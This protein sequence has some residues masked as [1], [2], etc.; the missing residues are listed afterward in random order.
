LPE[1]SKGL[2]RETKTNTLKVTYR[3]YHSK[4]LILSLHQTPTLFKGSDNSE[5][6]GGLTISILLV[7]ISMSLVMLRFVPKNRKLRFMPWS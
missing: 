5:T 3:E 4:E 7:V 1:F 6:I 2:W